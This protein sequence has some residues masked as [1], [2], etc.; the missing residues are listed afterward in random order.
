MRPRTI[1]ELILEERE[2]SEDLIRS[3]FGFKKDESG[4]W[5]ERENIDKIISVFN[6]S[7]EESR[8]IYR[9]CGNPYFIHPYS[10][11]KILA[12]MDASD[13]TIIVS[14]LHDLVED[15][16]DREREEIS[17]YISSHFGPETLELVNIVSTALNGDLRT[18]YREKLRI[19]LN[20]IDGI[21]SK[22]PLVV[23]SKDNIFFPIK[24]SYAV[25]PL[26]VKLAD[27]IDNI[28]TIY[29]TRKDLYSPKI[30]NSKTDP[31]RLRKQ[32]KIFDKAFGVLEAVEDYLSGQKD[33][34]FKDKLSSLFKKLRIS[35]ET[36]LKNEIYRVT[37]EVRALESGN[38]EEYKK[39]VLLGIFGKNNEELLKEADYDPEKIKESIDRFNGLTPIKMPR[40]MYI[41]DQVSS[42][43][44][45]RDMMENYLRLIKPRRLGIQR[46]DKIKR[47]LTESAKETGLFEIKDDGHT[48]VSLEKEPTLGYLKLYVAELSLMLDRWLPIV[49]QKAV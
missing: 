28:E 26:M 5:V 47:C 43:K 6:Y 44:I 33:C 14:L 30:D 32:R 7:R 49:Y 24:E 45:S 3:E 48:I 8:G 17:S 21:K 9:I 22:K 25:I 34:R 36:Q 31:L 37:L 41:L 38:P 2:I 12:D 18:T 15:S 10:T 11:A 4:R 40:H 35:I 19:M 46:F 1:E 39:A 20:K 16:K 23:S 27:A 13:N 42:K 29:A